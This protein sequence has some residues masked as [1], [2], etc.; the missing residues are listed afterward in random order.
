MNSGTRLYHTPRV[1]TLYFILYHSRYNTYP[2]HL[3]TFYSDNLG[4]YSLFCAYLKSKL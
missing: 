4:S 3:Y 2:E 1:I